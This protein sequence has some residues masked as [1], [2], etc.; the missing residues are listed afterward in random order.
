MTNIL[1]KLTQHIHHDE[2]ACFLNS[3][4]SS[5]FFCFAHCTD[6]DQKSETMVCS[7]NNENSDKLLEKSYNML[8]KTHPAHTS[9]RICCQ[10]PTPP[11]TSTARTPQ[12]R[13][14]LRWGGRRGRQ[15]C[16]WQRAP[17]CARICPNIGKSGPKYS[18]ISSLN[19]RKSGLEYSKL[20]LSLTEHRKISAGMRPYL[21]QT[22]LIEN[23]FY[24]FWSN[25]EKSGPEL[26]NY[27]YIN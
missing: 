9:W 27:Y 15:P 13:L 5:I 2:Y 24:I 3:A 6:E 12:R 25:V 19:I 17:A 22:T 20:S 4:D 14:R 8:S 21:L 16:W 11:Q 10:K 18:K 7:W 26:I 1:S 23:K